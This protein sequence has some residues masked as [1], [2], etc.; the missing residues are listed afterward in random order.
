VTAVPGAGTTARPGA[1]ASSSPRRGSVPGTERGSAFVCLTLPASE[2]TPTPARVRLVA[3]AA[4]GIDY[5]PGR[6]PRLGWPLPVKW[7]D[8]CG[9][10]RYAW[11]GERRGV[12]TLPNNP[13]AYLLAARL[14]YADLAERLGLRGDLL[15]AGVTAEGA[16]CD[17]PHS[18][19][20][21]A[22]AAGLLPPDSATWPSPQTRPIHLSLT[23]LAAR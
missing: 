12:A 6:V 15:L 7:T 18:V 19:V 16:P 10:R 20:H 14:G 13:A 4:D 3:P 2:A 22:V 21:A 9:G 17:I 5:T 23:M 11:C 1:G 8:T